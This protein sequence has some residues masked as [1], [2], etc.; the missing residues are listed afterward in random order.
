MLGKMAHRGPDAEGVWASDRLVLGNRRLK[1]LDLSDE[2][3]QPFSDGNDVLVFN[4]RI[5]NYRELRSELACRHSFRTECDTEVL[6]RALQE[7]GTGALQRIYGQ[8]AFA[9]YSRA[10]G[11]LLLARDHVGICP[12]YLYETDDFLYFSSEVHPLLKFHSGLLESDAVLD[13][14]TYRY[15]IQNGKT[16]FKDIR[17]FNPAHYSLIDLQSGSRSDRR[18]WRLEFNTRPIEREAAQST[19]N[20]LLDDE[21]ARQRST[22]VPVGLYL[23]GGIDSGALLAGYSRSSPTIEA[24]TLQMQEI[25]PDVIRVG[26]LARSIGFHP[27]ILS[28]PDEYFDQLGNVVEDLEEPFGDLIICANHLLARTAAG[29]VKVVLSGEGGDEAF[30]GYDHQRAFLKLLPLHSNSLLRHAASGILAITPAWLFARLQ[31]YPG[32]FAED[33]MAKVRGV[34]AGMHKPADAYAQLVSLFSPL[35]LERLFTPEFWQQ[36]SRHADIKSIRDA[37]EIDDSIWKSVFRVEIEQ[38]TMIVNLIKQERFGMHFSLEGC[39]PFASKP[40][41]EF[42]ASLPYEVLCTKVNKELILNYSGQ[43]VMRKKPFSFFHDKKHLSRL[44]ALMDQFVTPKQAES[45]GIFS[46]KELFQLRAAA[47]SGSILGVKKAMAVL[48]FAVWYQRF[49]LRWR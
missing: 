44:L 10:E 17:R 37:F 35:E 47:E 12:L 13:Y 8:F 22:D 14:F 31:S 16:L 45:N 21:I 43:K 40:V 7:W 46:P 11:T 19:L 1:I 5:F 41:L 2:A 25:D 33:E 49:A 26:E 29:K 24:F 34:V 38:L 18:Y 39:V 42:V 6:F 3:N 20:A 4:G 48:V 28:F 36:T 23:S 32:H 30:F 27:N 9:F 15:N